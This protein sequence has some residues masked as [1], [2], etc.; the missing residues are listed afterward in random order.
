MK[1]IQGNVVEFK[2]DVDAMETRLVHHIRRGRE[3][4]VGEENIVN[5][6][7]EGKDTLEYQCI[8]SKTLSTSRFQICYSI[9]RNHVLNVVTHA[10]ICCNVTL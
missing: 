4:R 6:K 10:I 9:T 3:G 1:L 5:R 7:H 2:R 8:N